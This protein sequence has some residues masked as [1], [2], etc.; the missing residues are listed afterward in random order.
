MEGTS[1]GSCARFLGWKKSIVGVS[2][3]SGQDQQI[4]IRDDAVQQVVFPCWMC[5]ITGERISFWIMSMP[6]KTGPIEI[7]S[8]L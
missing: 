8:P 2:W 5:W 3:A 4:W 7:I 6:G 1:K